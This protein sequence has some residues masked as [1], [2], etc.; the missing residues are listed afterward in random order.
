IVFLTAIALL[1]N[2]LLTAS[3]FLVGIKPFFGK[4]PKKFQKVVKPNIYLWLPRVILS[5][6]TIMIGIIPAIVDFSLIRSATT[7][8]LGTS[9]QLYL[10]LWHGFNIVLIL[11]IITII[12]GALLYFV[13]NPSNRNESRLKALDEV[14]PKLLITNIAL[15][16][17]W[18]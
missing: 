13:I 9:T 7:A 17:R 8:V 5:S 10:S 12:A 16:T 15:G 18:F 1:T 11:S 6:L 14:S 3:G 4:L 2:L